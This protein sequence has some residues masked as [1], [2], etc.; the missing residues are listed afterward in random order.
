MVFDVLLFDVGILVFNLWILL[1]VVL[2]WFC[3]WLIWFS[4]LLFLDEFFFGVC[5]S[6]LIWL[7][8]LVFFFC[9]E[10]VFC[11]VL[12]KSCWID[13]SLFCNLLILLFVFLFLGVWFIFCLS[14]F[15]I[16]WVFV[17]WL[18]SLLWI[19]FSSLF[20]LFLLLFLS[21]LIDLSSWFC[22]D[23]RCLLIFVCNLWKSDWI[24]GISDFLFDWGLIGLCWLSLVMWFVMIFLCFV[25]CLV[26]F[27]LMLWS[28]LRIIVLCLL[29]LFD[30][31]ELSCLLSCWWCLVICLVS[32]LWIWLRCLLI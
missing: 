2:S 32:E 8:S 15:L 4:K 6:F 17:R 7:V 14:V 21:E 20:V 5:F 29:F 1:C 16:F 9:N 28:L 12:C 25:N 11:F 10:E 3:I 24:F 13:F 30:D 19:V 26:R 27:F 18:V 31:W 22:W 23:V